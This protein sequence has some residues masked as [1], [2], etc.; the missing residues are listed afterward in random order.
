M[1]EVLL[2]D[3]FCTITLELKKERKEDGTG[4]KFIRGLLSRTLAFQNVPIA[5][6]DNIAYTVA[7]LQFAVFTRILF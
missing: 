1:T 4:S 6:I 3:Y 2:P 7:G 5:F